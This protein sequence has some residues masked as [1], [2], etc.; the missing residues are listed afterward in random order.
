MLM[1][2]FAPT[3]WKRYQ[4]ICGDDGNIYAL[5]QACS[6]T[7]SKPLP[8]VLPTFL[9]SQSHLCTLNEHSVNSESKNHGKI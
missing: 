4:H 3:I 1:G 8:K 9:S 7:R 5:D 2:S 6:V